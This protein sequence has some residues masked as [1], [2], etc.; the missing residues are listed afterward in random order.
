MARSPSQPTKAC[1]NLLCQVPPQL[2]VFSEQSMCPIDLFDATQGSVNPASV[3]LCHIIFHQVPAEQTTPFVSLGP[4]LPV[5][6]GPWE[7]TRNIRTTLMDQHHRGNRTWTRPALASWQGLQNQHSPET[8]GDKE[9]WLREWEL[10]TP[11]SL[12]RWLQLD[13]SNHLGRHL[14]KC[15]EAGDAYLCSPA[16]PLSGLT[17]REAG[18]FSPGISTLWR[19]TGITST[20]GSERGADFLTPPILGSKLFL[21]FPLSLSF[22]RGLQKFPG[23]GSNLCHSSD[24]RSITH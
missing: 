19:A 21:F 16:T 3:W 6:N 20:M 13:T 5:L 17:S 14:A 4:Q 24:A 15:R 18:C 8:W 7:P 9:G 2:W 10:P 12:G 11:N 22:L 1:L 23:Q